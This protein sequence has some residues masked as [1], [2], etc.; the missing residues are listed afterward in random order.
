[1]TKRLE[2]LNRGVL[3]FLGLLLLA[4][5]VLGLL[6]SFDAFGS[7]NAAESVIP[8]DLTSWFA[9][10][11]W[12]WWVIVAALILVAILCLLW[13]RAQFSTSK[14]SRLDLERDDRHGR[15]VLDSKAIVGAVQDEVQSFP[16]VKRASARLQDVGRGPVMQLSVDLDE[17]A[18]V[19]DVRDRIETQT[20]PNVRH[21]LESD[22]LSCDVRLRVAPRERRTVL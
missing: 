21:S 22:Y 10:N 5:A 18:D 1:M 16:G 20:V 4:A 11:E 13:L 14:V 19:A 9:R 8:A 2:N 12:I 15:T 3:S 17:R 6:L 7:E